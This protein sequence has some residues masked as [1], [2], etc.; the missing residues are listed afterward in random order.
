MSILFSEGDED[1][2]RVGWERKR[3]III[4]LQSSIASTEPSVSQVSYIN[5]L[6]FS[7][8]AVKLCWAIYAVYINND[9]TFPFPANLTAVLV[10]IFSPGTDN[11]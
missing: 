3:K 10:T 5:I 8:G 4:A 7:F 1:F 11:K 9:F 6:N 2:C